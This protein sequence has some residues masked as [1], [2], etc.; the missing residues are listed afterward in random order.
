MSDK[1]VSSTPRGAP[2]KPKGVP[3]ALFYA[4]LGLITIA[5]VILLLSN[6]QTL[7]DSAVADVQSRQRKVISSIPP[8]SLPARG[9]PNAPV[10][11]ITFADFQCP[12]CGVFA[13]TQ[14]ADLLKAYVDTGKVQFLYHD[15]PL[16]QHKNAVPAAEAAHCAGDQNAFWPMHDRLFATQA[17]WEQSDQPAP[18][19]AGF[20]EQLKLDTSAF[21]QCMS[22][23]KYQARVRALHDA[24][25]KAGVTQTPTFTINGQ[26]LNVN[27]LRGA[28]DA[29]LATAK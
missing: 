22:G 9:S 19:F 28:I 23:H 14:E 12:A 18:M 5:G 25:L 21:A 13:T 6:T 15:F 8:E 3:M 10:Q 1:Q 7:H 26:A 20:A 16:T 11:V 24:A 17:Q 2:A 29:A 4:L 27:Q